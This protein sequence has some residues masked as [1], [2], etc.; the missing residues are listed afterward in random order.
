MEG[1]NICIIFYLYIFKFSLICIHAI[2]VDF[3]PSFFRSLSF[4]GPVPKSSIGTFSKGEE[5]R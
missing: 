1:Y 2:L 4:L 3:F 5:R